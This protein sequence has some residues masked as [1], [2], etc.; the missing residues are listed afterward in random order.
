MDL[1]KI[2]FQ[3]IKSFEEEKSKAVKGKIRYKEGEIPVVV[4]YEFN[5]GKD[6]PW[7]I[8]MRGKLPGNPSYVIRT[9]SNYSNEKEAEQDFE[10]LLKGIEILE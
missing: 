1:E 10:E 4:K 5:A 6:S 2:F 3:R 7:C 8:D 9:L